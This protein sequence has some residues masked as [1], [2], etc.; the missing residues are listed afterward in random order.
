MKI[1]YLAA[2]FGSITLLFAACTKITSTDIGTDLIPAVDG[3]NTK[4]TTITVYAKNAGT[5]TITPTLAQIHVVGNMEDPLFG[6]TDARINFQLSLPS[7]N[8]SFENSKENLFLDSVVLVLS[9]NGVWG[10]STRPV[11]LHVNELDNGQTFLPDTTAGQYDPYIGGYSGTYNNTVNLTAFTSLTDAPTTVYPTSLDDSIHVYNDSGINMIRIRL[12]DAF[13]ARLLNY[14]TL[15]AYKNDSTFHNYLKGLQVFADQGTYNNA[16]LK[17]GLTDDNTKLAL[18]YRYHPKDSAATVIDTT[19]RY[20]TVAGDCAHSNYI[21]RDRS[22]GEINAYLPPN[23]A[24]TNDNLIYIQAG[25]GTFATVTID[26]AAL[27]Q[28]PNYIIHRAELLLEQAVDPSDTYYTPPYLFLLAKNDTSQFVIPGF[29]ANNVSTA[30]AVFSSSYL[31]NYSDFGG[32]PRKNTTNNSL[33][34]FNISRYVQGIVTK[35]NKQHPFVLY[36]PF[37]KPFQLYESLPIT[38]SRGYVSNSPTNTAG[39]GRVR[40]YGGD[41]DLTNIHRMRLHIVYSE[42]H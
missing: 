6:T 11:T 25:P 28:M 29:N 24:D 18:Y 13:G 34:S 14:D 17:I 41:G 35:D 4:D 20:F 5:D 33:Y 16:L 19:V 22:K 1:N 27:A 37:N 36:A 3:V 9:Y 23:P 39:C 10:D 42:P 7:S 26:S 21:N 8:F 12:N 2:F 30:D 31:A 38:S 40:L 15:T 32:I